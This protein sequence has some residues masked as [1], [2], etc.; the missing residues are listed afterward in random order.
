[1]RPSRQ[2]E[3]ERSRTA[4]RVTALVVCKDPSQRRLIANQ[5]TL[6]GAH[7]A[8]AEGVADALFRAGESHPDLV[9][10]EGRLPDGHGID[11]C[12]RLRARLD[13]SDPFLLLLL[14]P[15]DE[16]FLFQAFEAGVD[17]YLHLPLRVQDLSSRIDAAERLL[18]RASIHAP[19]GAA[20]GTAEAS[21]A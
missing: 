20:D 6:R 7:V 9:L 2:V 18:H 10:A 4:A 16:R 14:L 21:R 3:L 13:G 8:E 15:E 19:D 11:L 12:R 17:D 1:M 5:L